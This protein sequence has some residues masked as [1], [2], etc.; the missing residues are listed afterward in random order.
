[1]LGALERESGVAGRWVELSDRRVNRAQQRNFGKTSQ[2]RSGRLVL[3]PQPLENTPAKL[4][5][6]E[7]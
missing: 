7:I 3:G 4:A 2:A 5:A 1:L 6:L